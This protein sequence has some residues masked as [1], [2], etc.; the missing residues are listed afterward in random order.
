MAVTM[1]NTICLLLEEPSVWSAQKKREFWLQEAQTHPLLLGFCKFKGWA[2]PAPWA[3]SCLVILA[4]TEGNT[5]GILAE[6][7]GAGDKDFQLRKAPH[8]KRH[9]NFMKGRIFLDTE[10][11]GRPSYYNVYLPQTLITWSK[12]NYPI[13]TRGHLNGPMEP[14]FEEEMWHNHLPEPL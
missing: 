6:S 7:H 12:W 14:H 5:K 2:I 11:Q 9:W 1:P 4:H 8:Q 10:I 3:W 13:G